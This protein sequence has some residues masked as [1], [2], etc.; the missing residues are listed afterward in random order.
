MDAIGATE[1]IQT[2]DQVSIITFSSDTH[3]H[4]MR[5][6]ADDKVVLRRR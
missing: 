4:K 6:E 1:I 3:I 5:N 2:Q